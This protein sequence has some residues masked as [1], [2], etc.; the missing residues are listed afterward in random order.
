[1]ARNLALILSPAY[2]PAGAE[3]CLLGLRYI[4][5]THYP[6]P[7]WPGEGLVAARG[8]Q[9]GSAQAAHGNEE[10]IELL[11]SADFMIHRLSTV[12]ENARSALECGSEAERSCR[13]DSKRQGGS[14]RFRTPRCLRHSDFLGSEE[15]WPG[16][17]FGIGTPQQMDDDV[18][19]RSTCSRKTEGAPASAPR[20]MFSHLALERGLPARIKEESGQD[21]RTRAA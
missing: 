18:I 6:R 8:D 15:S 14:W 20:P 4:N 12:H 1:M 10:C 19:M 2:P 13:L 17:F 16:S 11:D 9:T 21:G 5:R 7:C 3:T